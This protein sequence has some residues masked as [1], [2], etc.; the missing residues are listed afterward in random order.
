MFIAG[1]ELY[2]VYRHTVAKVEAL[3]L[4][5]Y[6][7]CPGIR[8][9]GGALGAVQLCHTSTGTPARDQACQ[10]TNSTLAAWPM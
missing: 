7:T 10:A 8:R 3:L 6:C 1:G 2:T 9:A 4:L 5:G